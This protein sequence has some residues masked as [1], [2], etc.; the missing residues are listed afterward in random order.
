MTAGANRS[1]KLASDNDPQDEPAEHPAIPEKY[2]SRGPVTYYYAPVTSTTPA[3]ALGSPEIV[4]KPDIVATDCGANTFFGSFFLGFPRFCGTSAAAPHAAG[5]AAI[6]HQ[7]APVKTPAQIKAA[8]KNT[9]EPVPDMPRGRWQ[10]P[11]SRRPAIEA[12]GPF[13]PTNDPPST[14][15]TPVKPACPRAPPDAYPAALPNPDPDAD[16]E[17][18]KETKSKAPG[19]APRHADQGSAGEGQEHGR[20]GQGHLQVRRRPEGREVECMVDKAK[21][22]KC[23]ASYKA[24]LLLGKHELKVRAVAS[25]APRATPDDFKFTVKLVASTRR[26]AW[27]RT[28]K[29]PTPAAPTARRRRRSPAG[30]SP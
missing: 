9:A 16:P 17:A 25:A 24:S 20:P 10:R 8:L 2:S 30:R 13:G 7:A 1:Y 6:M 23:G 18:R 28:M 15:V 4:E 29:W 21:W 12:L 27:R 14:L 22:N 19:T 3:A 5:V 26:A 11:D